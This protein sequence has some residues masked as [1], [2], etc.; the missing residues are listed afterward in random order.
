MVVFGI[1]TIEFYLMDGF[2]NIDCGFS[3]TKVAVLAVSYYDCRLWVDGSVLQRGC[4]L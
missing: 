1:P 2:L 3:F 4:L